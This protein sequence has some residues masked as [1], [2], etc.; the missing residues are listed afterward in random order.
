MTSYQI[1]DICIAVGES[2]YIERHFTL[3]NLGVRTIYSYLVEMVKQVLS[4]D[5]FINQWL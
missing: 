2:I 1:Y 4:I 5:I 3:A